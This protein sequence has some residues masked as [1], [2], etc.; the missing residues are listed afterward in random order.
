MSTTVLVTGGGR[1]IGRATVER[2]FEDD[3][4]AVIHCNDSKT[5][6]EELAQ[7]GEGTVVQADL[8]TEE[9]LRHLKMVIEE[10]PP[11]VLVNNAGI[12][13]GLDAS[14]IR[15]DEWERVFRVNATVPAVLCRVAA[16]SM[17]AGG[18]I[19]NVGSVRGL[20]YSTRPGISA[21]CASKA[22]LQNL[23]SSL[24]QHYAPDVRINAVAPGFTDTDMTSGLEESDRRDVVDKT[25]MDRFGSP[26]EIAEA[27]RFLCDRRCQFL[28]GETL[29]VDGGYSI[30][31]T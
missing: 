26:D 21:Y 2:F 23:T 1:G 9:G 5:R 27:I 31:D 15:Q 12:V 19:V 28:T 22:A 16:E 8:S 10:D 14:A 6:A 3:W 13:R 7:I 25:P 18:R 4:T 20:R 29:V 24:A 11:D 30:A 17:D